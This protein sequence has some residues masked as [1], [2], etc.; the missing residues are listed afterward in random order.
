M[1]HHPHEAEIELLLNNTKYAAIMRE[2]IS[3]LSPPFPVTL[4]KSSVVLQHLIRPACGTLQ[5]SPTFSCP[6]FSF[7]KAS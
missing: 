2:A 1:A 4:C 5:F 6:F 7:G 3:L